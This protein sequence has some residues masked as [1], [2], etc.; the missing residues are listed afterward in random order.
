MVNYNKIMEMLFAVRLSQN[1]P[2]PPPMPDNAQ[3]TSRMGN[4][5]FSVISFIIKLY[6]H[7]MI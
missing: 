2:P 1:E 6:R 5:K 7:F 4:S 3:R